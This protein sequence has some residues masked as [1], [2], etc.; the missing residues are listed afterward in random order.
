MNIVE[1]TLGVNRIILADCC[2]NIGVCLEIIQHPVDALEYYMKSLKIRCRIADRSGLLQLSMATTIENVAMIYRLMNR[3]DSSQ[4]SFLSYAASL[5]ENVIATRR[6]QLG[7]LSGGLAEAYF[8]LGLIELDR[9]LPKLS[10]DC[11]R[12]SLHIRRTIFG[13]H[14]EL[15]KLAE[16][17]VSL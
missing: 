7:P 17:L 6:A 16:H 2:H 5:M 12:K 14:H 10:R 11:F 9:R 4:N 8:N 15:T 3:K 1:S 13:S